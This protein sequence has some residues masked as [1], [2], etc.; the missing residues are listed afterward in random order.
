MREIVISR[1]LDHVAENG[2]LFDYDGTAVDT[3]KLDQLADEEL[4][5][6]YELMS[7]FMG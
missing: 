3:T 1:I 6:I 5:D 2:K 4:L 7:A